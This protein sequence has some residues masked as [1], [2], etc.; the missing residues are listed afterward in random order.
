MDIYKKLK[1]EVLHANFM[2]ITFRD[3]FAVDEPTTELLANSGINFFSTTQNLFLKD[4]LSSLFKL[5]DTSPKK[6]SQD[7]EQLVFLAR[8]SGHHEL[9]ERL[10]QRCQHIASVCSETLM[11]FAEG[12]IAHIDMKHAINQEH[13]DLLESVYLPIETLLGLINDYMNAYESA[14]HIPH[15][16]Y[17]AIFCNPKY[18]GDMLIRSLKIARAAEHILEEDRLD[19]M[20]VSE[21][22]AMAIKL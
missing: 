1:T 17:D 5:T 21:H 16:S 12:R 7:L 2:W 6:E 22:E 20:G 9:G 3:V 18:C 14:L 10:D 19:A 13:S 11:S 4:I 8:Q 15:T